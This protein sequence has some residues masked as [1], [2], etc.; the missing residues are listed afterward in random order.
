MSDEEK[1]KS[2]CL[3]VQLVKSQIY[4]ERLRKKA[5]IEEILPAL[6]TLKVK[7]DWIQNPIK[8]E[9][10]QTQRNYRK[11]PQRCILV[12]EEE[13]KREQNQSDDIHAV[14]QNKQM[15]DSIPEQQDQPPMP[16]QKI[17]IPQ[18]TEK[19]NFDEPEA[20]LGPDGKP[21]EIEDKV[22]CEFCGRRFGRSVLEKHVIRCLKN[23]D[24]IKGNK[25]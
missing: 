24:R 10:S 9:V 21:I 3:T 19:L 7:Y 5:A 14:T 16:T 1:K 23:P 25:K 11:L 15:E 4:I 17:V 20:M 18:V 6:D 8:Q 13:Y 22:P 12:S 2:F